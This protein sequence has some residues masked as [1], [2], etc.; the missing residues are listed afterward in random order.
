MLSF[1]MV[2]N[3]VQIRSKRPC[4]WQVRRVRQLTRLVPRYFPWL[5][6]ATVSCPTIWRGAYCRG[7]GRGRFKV[8]PSRGKKHTF[9]APMVSRH[10]IGN[11]SD[12]VT[13]KLGP[14]KE[15]DFKH[16]LPDPGTFLQQL[17]YHW[18]S[19]VY[20]PSRHRYTMLQDTQLVQNQPRLRHSWSA[21]TMTKPI[22]QRRQS[23]GVTT[24]PV[25]LP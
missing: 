9:P 1:G 20:I 16:P 22:S 8:A 11:R 25:P 12:T 23:G 2:W 19:P 17:L 21:S 13:C 18:S 6:R 10:P 14:R 3:E 4:F 7:I 5:V 15:A 24:N